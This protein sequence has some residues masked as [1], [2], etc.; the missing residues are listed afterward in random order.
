MNVFISRG[1]IS[2]SERS[3]SVKVAQHAYEG[4]RKHFKT[5]GSCNIPVQGTLIN[6]CAKLFRCRAMT[7]QCGDIR[8][9]TAMLGR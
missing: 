4:S 7:G 6:C 9:M 2:L 8:K 3:L 5:A 1:A